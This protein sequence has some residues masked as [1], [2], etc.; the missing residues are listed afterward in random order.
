[1]VKLNTLKILE[2]QITGK[3]VYR[4]TVPAKY[5]GQ[6]WDI[7]RSKETVEALDTMLETHDQSL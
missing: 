6:R 5:N 7:D 2:Y 3:D 1:M 4:L